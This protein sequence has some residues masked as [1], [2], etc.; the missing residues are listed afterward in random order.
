MPES[1]KVLRRGSAD[2]DRVSYTHDA[3][4]ELVST[5]Q[6]FMAQ[7]KLD[8][9]DVRRLADYFERFA[10][11]ALEDA[12]YV[13]TRAAIAFIVG[14]T[15]AHYAGVLSG[16]EGSLSRVLSWILRWQIAFTPKADFEMARCDRAVS[17]LVRPE[18]ERAVAM[19]PKPEAPK[20]SPEKLAQLARSGIR[21]TGPVA[22]V[23]RSTT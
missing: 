9:E 21:L 18:K 19:K 22:D 16:K 8:K 11:S 12:G 10:K 7:E 20:P 13:P 6:H 15:Y 2:P 5:L 14:E 4:Y 1:K 23:D 3:E 17:P